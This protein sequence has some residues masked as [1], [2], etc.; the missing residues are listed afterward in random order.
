MPDDPKPNSIDAQVLFGPKFLVR[1]LQRFMRVELQF[2]GK[3]EP[4]GA[5]IV[6]TANVLLPA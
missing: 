2:K 6:D 4:A 1:T 5:R 3:A